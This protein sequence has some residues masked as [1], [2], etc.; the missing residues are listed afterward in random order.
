MRIRTIK[1]EFWLHEGLCGCSEFTR[2]LAIALLNWADDH[3][4]FMAH[5]S[6]LRGSLFPFL[7][8][9]KTIPGSLQDLSRVG[10]IE[11]GTDIQ[12]RPVGRVINFSKHQ[13]VDKPK[14]S[15]IKDLCKFQ[16]ESK[17]DPRCIQDASREEGKGIGKE[18]N[19]MDT[20]QP[21][22]GED[23]EIFPLFP[24]D[25]NPR[26]A[27][28]WKEWI[29]YREER[30]HA[31]GKDRLA[32]T[33]RA[34][35]ATINQILAYSESH[36]IAAVCNRIEEAIA[37]G[38]KG[39]NFPTMGA[40]QAR[41]DVTTYTQIKIKETTPEDIIRSIGGSEEAINR[42]RKLLAKASA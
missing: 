26:L 37:A 39:P 23:L 27:A 4:Y 35:N 5:P 2:L 30:S 28:A 41:N 29:D 22:K 34:A 36:G 20:P 13:R 21:P 17:T 42:H 24:D 31:K 8:S 38:W 12:G 40:T 16:D 1:P 11:L 25:K 32:W 14:P 6:L 15:L 33:P 9:S 18:R 3:G 7:D 10:W 19:G